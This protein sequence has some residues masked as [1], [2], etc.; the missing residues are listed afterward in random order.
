MSRLRPEWEA[1]VVGGGPAGLAA[2]IQLSR[3]GLRTALLE[4]DA[5]GGQAGRLALI[6]NAPGWPDGISGRRL[7]S[8]YVRQARAWGL[9]TLKGELVGLCPGPAAQRLLLADGRRLSARSVVLA[10]GA[11]FKSLRAPGAGRLRGRGIFHAAFD[12]P[13]N[14]RGRRV[15]V[16]GGGEAAVH[17]A[18][19]LAGRARRVFLIARGPLSA[20]RLLLSRLAALPNVEILRGRVIRVEGRSRV[21]ALVLRGARGARARLPV[22]AVFVLI[23]ARASAWSRLRGRPGVFVAGDARGGVER[24]VAVA[25]GDGMAAAVRALRWLRE[26]A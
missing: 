12:V 24:Q 2:G 10:T 7:M 11:C 22:A 26:R 16:V 5:L 15:A 20:H 25:A 4:R 3:A 19:H 17:Q 14:W 1:I 18:V 6:E 21:S 23:G 8:T 13:A 9:R